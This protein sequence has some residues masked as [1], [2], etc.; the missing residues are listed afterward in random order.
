MSLFPVPP[1]YWTDPRRWKRQKKFPMELNRSLTVSDKGRLKLPVSQETLYIIQEFL[2]LLYLLLKKHTSFLMQLSACTSFSTRLSYTV[3]NVGK[4]VIFI[5]VRE[6]RSGMNS[7]CEL[8]H[9]T[10]STSK[11]I[12]HLCHLQ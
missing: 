10:K 2:H 1:F 3:S 7:D 4:A 12:G 11:S 8:C 6:S 5:K 9:D